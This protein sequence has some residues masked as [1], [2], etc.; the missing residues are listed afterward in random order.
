[1]VLNKLIDRNI[2]GYEPFG[3]DEENHDGGGRDLI[4]KRLDS[5]RNFDRNLSVRTTFINFNLKKYSM[6]KIKEMIK[7]GSFI[8]GDTI[9]HMSGIVMIDEIVYSVNMEKGHLNVMEYSRNGVKKGIDD[10]IPEKRYTNGYIEHLPS[11]NNGKKR[12]S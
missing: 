2:S 7:R 5:S 3:N 12:L 10:K 1:M 11:H 8:V 4:F 6:D 9:T